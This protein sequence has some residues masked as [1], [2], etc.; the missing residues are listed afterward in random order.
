[1]LAIMMIN[2]RRYV[3]RVVSLA[4]NVMH[5]LIK[6][7][8]PSVPSQTLGAML[9]GEAQ[10]SSNRSQ[11]AAIM[12]ANRMDTLIK[13]LELIFNSFEASIQANQKLNDLLGFGPR[14]KETGEKTLEELKTITAGQ[15]DQQ[16]LLQ[17]IFDIN[18]DIARVGASVLE[19]QRHGQSELALSMRN[20]GEGLSKVAEINVGTSEKTLDSLKLIFAG[21][22]EQQRLLQRIV[23]VNGDII[24]V[25]ES[26]LESQRHGQSELTLSMRTLSEGLSRVAEINTAMG[27][28]TLDGLKTF[29]SGQEE[30]QRL[31]H[32]I[33][34]INTDLL[35]VS[36]TVLDTQRQSQTDLALDFKNVGEHFAKIQEINIGSGRHLFDIKEKFVKVQALLGTVEQISSGIGHET[37]LVETLI[38]EV[39]RR[40][41][42]LLR[43]MKNFGTLYHGDLGG[44]WGVWLFLL[45]KC[46]SLETVSYRQVRSSYF[47]FQARCN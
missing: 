10:E 14:M 3:S 17:Q 9:T 21:S 40:K 5:E 37:L 20:L 24:R 8:R 28:K 27:E 6:L 46:F 2:L 41:R 25:G 23:D 29:S 31:S 44:R 45:L 12:V 36:N 39:L 4:R 33:V 43:C 19:G 30:Q 18:G 42:G 15:A 35:R 11:S 47:M 38:E 13:K 26:V 7:S 16:R 1:M 32:K 34:D 22:T